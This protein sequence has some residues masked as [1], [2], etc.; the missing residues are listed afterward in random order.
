MA[1][2]NNCYV[3]AYSTITVDYWQHFNH[4]FWEFFRVST[5][6][7]GCSPQLRPGQVQLS[8]PGRKEDSYIAV[9]VRC[10]PS[11]PLHGSEVKLSIAPRYAWTHQV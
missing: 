10:N 11:L 7:Q 9:A 6:I 8:V 3:G 1:V 5:F 4:T 2:I